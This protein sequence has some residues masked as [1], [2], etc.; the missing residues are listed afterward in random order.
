[1]TRSKRS[2]KAV[3]ASRES[4]V[5]TAGFAALAV[6]FAAALFVTAGLA[7]AGSAAGVTVHA[8]KSKLGVILV[9]SRGQ[10]L[11]LFEKDRKGH[12][13]CT[14]TCI[15][16]WPP[17]LTLGTPHAATGVKQGLLGA[18]MRADG[19][20]QVTYA[21]HPLYRFIGDQTRGQT[22]GQGLSK[23]GASWYVVSPKGSKIDSD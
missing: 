13:A 10:T 21:G 23:F 6:L 9:S 16:Y 14:G 8:A 7:R 17:L 2:T 3:A 4:S 12:S 20:D 1:M 19:S 5:R 15:K 18:T 11:Y 22:T